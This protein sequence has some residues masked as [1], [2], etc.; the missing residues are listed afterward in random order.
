MQ[1][2]TNTMNKQL[3]DFKLEMTKSLEENRKSTN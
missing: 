1:I 2:Q 3:E